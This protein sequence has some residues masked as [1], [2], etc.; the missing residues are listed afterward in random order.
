MKKV[1]IVEDNEAIREGI[2]DVLTLEGFE[3]E[4]SEN[5]EKA[6][7][8]YDKFNPD[9][10][11]SDVMMPVMDGFEL[12]KNIQQDRNLKPVPFIFLTALSENRDI[13][14]GMKLGADDFLIK[15]FSPSELVEAIETQSTKYERRKFT[16]LQQNENQLNEMKRERELVIK[17]MHHRVKHNLAIISAFIELDDT[18]VAEDHMNNIRERIFALASVH[19]EAYSS[20]VL[21]TVDIC[22][23]TERIFR[24]IQGDAEIVL[25]KSFRSFELDISTAI[26]FGLLM[27][28]LG[29]KLLKIGFRDTDSRKLV[30]GACAEDDMFL[31]SILVNSDVAVVPKAFPDDSNS[32]LINTFLEQLGGTLSHEV[33][34][35]EGINYSLR[36]DI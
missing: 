4:K 36:L 23:M 30:F 7:Q 20:D 6:L 18:P 15:P 2:V 26:P 10:V 14:Q 12:L 19:E 3:V 32:L 27:L 34:P 35:G 5:G 28:D 9:I 13:R 24:R 21:T 16:L 8:L 1:L 33:L 11:V 29:T 25:E 22:K 17:E 31:I